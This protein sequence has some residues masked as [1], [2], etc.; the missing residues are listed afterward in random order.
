MSGT[1][2]LIT[3]VWAVLGGGTAGFFLWSRRRIRS[4]HQADQVDTGLAIL[5]FGR[6]FPDEAIRQLAASENGDMIFLRLW[7]GRCGCMRR[8][9]RSYLCHI[10]D[11]SAVQITATED[12]KGI[13]LSFDKL[14]ALSGT[15]RFRS[16][17]EAAEVSLWI[18]GSLALDTMRREAT[19]T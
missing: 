4:D 19:S 15:Y 17:S 11:P 6:A 5:E 9:A 13:T 8:N 3:M 10:I 18:L 14:A 16:E 2:L 7:N 12:G 1:D